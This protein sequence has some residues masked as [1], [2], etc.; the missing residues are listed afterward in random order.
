MS[1]WREKK[2]EREGQ[3]G[4][5][6][7]TYRRASFVLRNFRANI[8]PTSSVVGVDD[9]IDV[10]VVQPSTLLLPLALYPIL[11][12]ALPPPLFLHP[13]DILPR[14]PDNR[15]IHPL[16][17]TPFTRIYWLCALCKQT[18]QYQSLNS[19]Y[20]ARVK[21]T[22]V[23]TRTHICLYIRIHSPV[24]MRFI[25][26]RK[27]TFLCLTLYIYIYLHIYTHDDLSRYEFLVYFTL[28]L[29]C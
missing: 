17:R 4:G 16:T 20:Y 1:R 9:D 10:D 14:D 22:D 27:Y 15:L 12:R 21:A 3:Q 6:E 26:V 29:H 25:C 13:L 5:R 28:T 8:S 18:N 24:S 2:G 23:H 19:T 7:R 11:V